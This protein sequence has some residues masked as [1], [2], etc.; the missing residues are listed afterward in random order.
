VTAHQDALDP[1]LGV[2][3][4][5][6]ASVEV[7]IRDHLV[8]VVEDRPVPQGSKTRYGKRVVEDNADLLAP[9]REGVKAAAIT[10]M[11]AMYEDAPRPLFGEGVPVAVE[12]T[13]TFARPGG[14]Y[15]T[16]RNA[17]VL[18]AWAP[19]WRASPPDVDKLA[20]G[21]FDAC[22]AAGVWRDDAQAVELTA[23]KCYPGGHRDALT[24]P[25]AVVRVKAVAP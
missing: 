22:T 14:H 1:D 8:F 18:K 19:T 11:R 16:G 20:R 6:A 23:R 10:G 24:I 7:G 15:G 12:I 4:I 2:Q 13:F 25:G 17:A 5:P 21:V 9:W 3:P